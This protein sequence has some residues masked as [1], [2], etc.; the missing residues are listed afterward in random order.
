MRQKR[1][2]DNCRVGKLST[3]LCWCTLAVVQI[4]GQQ[5]PEGNYARSK[6]LRFSM[7]SLSEQSE[8]LPTYSTCAIITRSLYIFQTPLSWSMLAVAQIFGHKWQKDNYA[9]SKWLWLSMTPLF[10]W[11][12]AWPTYS[13]CANS[14]RS[15]YIF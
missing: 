5:R 6:R 3:A 9:H 13:T 12:E 14:T 10:E 7:T 2:G 4:F 1:R 15:F 8:A 11:S